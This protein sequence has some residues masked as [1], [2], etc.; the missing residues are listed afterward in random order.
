MNEPRKTALVIIIVM[1][2]GLA[3]YAFERL[4]ETVGKWRLVLAGISF[5]VLILLLGAHF[6]RG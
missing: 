6:A 4:A 1:V 3:A 5:A 2:I